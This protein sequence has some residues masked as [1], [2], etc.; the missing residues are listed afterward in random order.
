[1][2]TFFDLIYSDL[3]VL[4]AMD[5]AA[6]EH[7]TQ[8]KTELGHSEGALG[9]NLNFL[10]AGPRVFLFDPTFREKL[11]NSEERSIFWKWIAAQAPKAE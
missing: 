9:S 5:P 6:V 11:Y 8:T 7:L 1:M 2:M 3:G 10:Q 4:V